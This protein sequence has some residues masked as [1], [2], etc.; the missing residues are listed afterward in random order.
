MNLFIILYDFLKLL[1][2]FSPLV[3]CFIFYLIFLLLEFLLL[4]CF[5]LLFLLNDLFS[6]QL[7][8]S[9]FLTHISMFCNSFIMKF[10]LTNITNSHNWC[11]FNTLWFIELLLVFFIILVTHNN[12]IIL[13]INCL[14]QFKSSIMV[15]S[16]N[17]LHNFHN[18]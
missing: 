6:L 16:N 7:I 12:Y 4:L 10:S 13:L 17:V 14:F 9:C 11:V 5:L 3:N 2:L 15:L 8:F 18:T 1:M